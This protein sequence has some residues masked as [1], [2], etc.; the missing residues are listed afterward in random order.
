MRGFHEDVLMSRSTMT[1]FSAPLHR[2]SLRTLPSDISH[3]RAVRGRALPLARMFSRRQPGHCVG[4]FHSATNLQG[5][6]TGG[7]CGACPSAGS[8]RK[9]GVTKLGCTL[10]RRRH[11]LLAFANLAQMKNLGSILV[12]HTLPGKVSIL[13]E[14][15][16][17]QR[18]RLLHSPFFCHAHSTLAYDRSLTSVHGPTWTTLRRPTLSTCRSSWAIVCW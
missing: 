14:T 13:S 4:R 6:V 8:F 2:M 7:C 1:M 10:Q 16:D 9:K 3:T 18:N 15:L 12:S 11:E 17:A 5:D